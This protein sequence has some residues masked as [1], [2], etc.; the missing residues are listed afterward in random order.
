MALCMWCRSGIGWPELSGFRD[1]DDMSVLRR[2]DD[3]VAVDCIFGKGLEILIHLDN[4]SLSSLLHLL[5]VSSS[6]YIR[7]IL[8]SSTVYHFPTTKSTMSCK[9]NGLPCNF[10]RTNP[11][12]YLLTTCLSSVFLRMRVV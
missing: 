6:R 3:A 11:F 5:V 2:R 1:S 8:N 9:K 10:F 4:R 12:I 7:R